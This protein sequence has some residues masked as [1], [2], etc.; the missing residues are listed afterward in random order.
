MQVAAI[1]LCKFEL[2]RKTVLPKSKILTS[3]D[4]IR[5]QFTIF[6]MI[7]IKLFFLKSNDENLCELTDYKLFG[8]SHFGLFSFH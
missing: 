1:N 2:I 7:S 6:D 5:R 3:I 4:E 8:T